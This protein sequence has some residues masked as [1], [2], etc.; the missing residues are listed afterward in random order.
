MYKEMTQELE[1]L[2]DIYYLS[3]FL[4][5]WFLCFALYAMCT[6]RADVFDVFTR[7]TR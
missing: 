1:K 4:F 3:L 7:K 2:Q 5:F 6:R